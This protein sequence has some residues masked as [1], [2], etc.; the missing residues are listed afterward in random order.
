[1][2]TLVV[3]PE[4]LSAKDGVAA[5]RAAQLLVDREVP[6][7]LVCRGGVELRMVDELLSQI[8]VGAR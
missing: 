4:L 8:L 5:H 1:M 3:A 2:M 6:Q 7:E